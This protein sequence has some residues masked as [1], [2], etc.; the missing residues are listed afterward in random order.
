MDEIR[1]GHIYDT[2]I[3][4]ALRASAELGSL[5]DTWPKAPRQV[6]ARL[7]TL[8]AADAVDSEALGRPRTAGE[9]VEDP[10]GLGEAMPPEAALGRME[11][12]YSLLNS[13]TAVRLWCR[14]LSYT[15]SSWRSVPS[16]GGTGWSP[17]PRNV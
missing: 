1:E 10:L 5:V 9:R 6:L 15:E 12:L 13:R 2:R 11:G 8:A 7:H 3:K 14:R 16:A 17:V 4:G